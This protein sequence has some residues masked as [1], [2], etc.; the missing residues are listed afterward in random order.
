MNKIHYGCFGQIFVCIVEKDPR[1]LGLLKEGPELRGTLVHS[2]QGLA[3]GMCT[4]LGTC[5]YL[6]YSLLCLKLWLYISMNVG[7]A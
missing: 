2:N 1:A 3:Y 7:C 4:D 6:Y 5:M